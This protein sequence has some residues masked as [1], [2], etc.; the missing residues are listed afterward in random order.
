MNLSIRE[1]IYDLA[2]QQ[3]LRMNVKKIRLGISSKQNE[4]SK[5]TT[6]EKSEGESKSHREDEGYQREAIVGP[7]YYP[8]AGP[9]LRALPTHVC[10][11][12][13]RTLPAGSNLS[14]SVAI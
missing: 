6:S 1:E 4:V 11:S 9:F 3:N 12:L 8:R 7:Q 10:G 2:A 5:Q 13:T 14:L